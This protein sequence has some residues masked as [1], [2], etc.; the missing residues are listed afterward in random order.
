MS[1]TQGRYEQKVGNT[2]AIAV[3][4]PND[5]DALAAA[6]CVLTRTAA[7]DYNYTVAASKTVT[8]G[9]NL[10]KLLQRTGQL[11]FIQEQFGT[12]AGVAGPTTV[13]NTSDPDAKSSPYIPP[14]TGATQLSV[15]TGFFPKGIKIMGFNVAYFVKTVNLTALTCRVDKTVYADGVA[16]AVT[17]VLASAANGLISTFAATPKVKAVTLA[18]AQQI[19]RV[20]DLSALT[21]ELGVQTP[22][23]GTFELERIEVLY[24]YNFN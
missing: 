20:T 13:A 10:G 5:V 16:V 21:F 24:H 22:V 14:F 19:Y 18:A 4:G 1:K 3:F 11:P 23:G 2:D 8:F 6:D 12:A 17:A 7:G 9:L 15:Q